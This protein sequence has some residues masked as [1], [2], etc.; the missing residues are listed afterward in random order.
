MSRVDELCK[1]YAEKSD[2]ELLTLSDGFEDLT[3]DA[4]QALTQVMQERGLERA[5]PG[6]AETFEREVKEGALG[7]DE[8]CVYTF[9]DAL[10]AKEALRIL[11]EAGVDVRA[12]DWNELDPQESQNMPLLRIG[13]VVFRDQEREA[14]KALHD[15]MGLFPQAEVDDPFAQLG[16]LMVVGFFERA[17]ALIAARALGEKGISYVWKDDR[18]DE[19]ATADEVTIEVKGTR[20]D[21]AQAVVEKALGE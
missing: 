9:N 11:D 16:S 19:T 15:G 17:D 13:V 8:V 5:E 12:V 10:S 14:R 2:A 7:A 1:V 3:D 21:E 18:D 4:Q 20:L 6:V